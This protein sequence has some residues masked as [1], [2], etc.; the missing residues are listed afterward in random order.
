MFENKIIMLF[1][2]NI[3]NKIF[4]CLIHS[5]KKKVKL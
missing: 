2:H 3:I 4:R 5:S 1:I